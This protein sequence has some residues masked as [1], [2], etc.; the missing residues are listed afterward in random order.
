[1]SQRLPH[2]VPQELEKL[3]AQQG[4]ENKEQTLCVCSY[5]TRS[6]DFGKTWLAIDE[7]NIS[8][9]RNTD[10]YEVAS[11]FELE[12]LTAARTLN[13]IGG[14]ALAVD[15]DGKP[16]EVLRFPAS[17]ARLFGAIAGGLQSTRKKKPPEP[18]KDGD[19][20]KETEQKAEVKP[21][22]KPEVKPE[23]KPEEKP[24]EKVEE[25]P[26]TMAEAM[27]AMKAALKEEIDRCCPECGRQYPK[28]TKVCPFCVS[29]SRALFRIFKFAKPYR[30]QL[31]LITILMAGSSAIQL[32]PPIVSG[33]LI[34]MVNTSANSGTPVDV[35]RLLWFLTILTGI[36]IA[37]AAIAAVRVRIAVAIGAN[38]TN[39]IRIAA[40]NHLQRLSLNYFEKRQ[41]GALMSRVSH[42]SQ[43]I[44]GFLVD[45]VQYTIIN[46]LLMIGIGIVLVVKNPLLGVLVLL[47]A[48][49]VIAISKFVWH[50]IGSSFRKWWDSVS[51]M[52]AYLSDTLSGSREIKATGQQSRIAT[53]FESK[54]TET[55]NRIITAERTWATLVPLLNLIIQTST[56]LVWY[57]GAKAVGQKQLTVGDL[58]AFMSLMG[59]MFGPLQVLTRLNDWLARSLTAAERIF[60][61]LDTQP[62][63][64][65]APNAQPT[66]ITKGQIEIK[67]IIFGYEKHK[68]VVK[69]I[70]F[71]VNPGE[72]IGLV[73]KSGSGKSTLIKLLMRLYDVDQ[74]GILI[75]GVDL[76]Q[77]KRDDFHRR[78]AVVMQDSF[79]FNGSI[80]ENISFARPDASYAQIVQAAVA[81]NAHEFIMRLPNGYDSQVGERGAKLSG[82]ERQRIAIARALVTDPKILIL[83]EA[84]SSVDTETE[85]KIQQALE[86]LV[87]GR[88]TIAIAH[89]LSTLRYASRLLVLEE[90]KVK[91]TGTHDELMAKEKGVYRKLVE[92][93]TEWARTVSVGGE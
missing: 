54:S 29:R 66:E 55:T 72:M 10:G 37:Q 63:I 79:L 25:K 19:K 67:D 49:I 58:F 82:G 51:R 61:L 44:E 4:F 38:V 35:S 75:D 20:P 6:S 52:N 23:A 33:K 3:L 30:T 2:Q 90:G 12:K 45:G 21:D 71:T 53:T 89:R 78:V 34:D 16:T 28:H 62:D 87:K 17:Q 60:E 5:L 64:V 47:P 13:F 73:G 83:D 41:V 36:M 74:G 77:L 42:D 24:E 8:V 70:S 85:Q 18:P 50:R 9:I 32:F 1:M 86:R 7:K 40:Y 43:N 92:I 26:K 88:T 93:Q 65:D 27:V 56:I 80:A 59:L 14:G 11:K 68:P 31:A 84:T 46:V 76:R 69:G 81:A 91:E 22:E 48:P 15:V 57:F 39:S